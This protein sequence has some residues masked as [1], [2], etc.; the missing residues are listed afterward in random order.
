MPKKKLTK[1]QVRA[2]YKTLMKTTSKL[3]F[4]KLEHPDSLVPMSMTVLVDLAK[5]L[6]NAFN[7]IK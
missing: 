5:K 1:A 3:V 4:D 7:R 6:A 2:Q